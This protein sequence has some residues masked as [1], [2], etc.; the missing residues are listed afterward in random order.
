MRSFYLTI[1]CALVLTA[2][3][4]PPP[5][6]GPL[7]PVANP[8]QVMIP[9]PLSFHEARGALRL[10]MEFGLMPGLY[11]ATRENSLGTYYSSEGHPVWQRGVGVK[12]AMTNQGGFWVPKDEG[13]PPQIYIISEAASSST[14][15]LDGEISRRV[16]GLDSLLG[17]NIAEQSVPNAS[18]AQAAV[19]GAIG[20]AIVQA[21]IDADVG[22]I[23]F[24]GESKNSQFNSSLQ[25]AVKRG[26]AA[27]H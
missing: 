18:V 15:D 10:E 7:L 16:S 1:T 3:A 27:I 24:I 9:E 22:S 19:G 2:C 5:A 11:F 17:Y 23:Y 13:K 25:S 20:G 6:G 8:V 26:T 12:G 14:Q 4:T 21:F